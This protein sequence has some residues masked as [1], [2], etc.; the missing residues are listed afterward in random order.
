MRKY[1][2]FMLVFSLA[3]SSGLFIL[4]E[5]TE[6]A[7]SAWQSIPG[8]SGCKVRVWTDYTA[9]TASADTNDYCGR[10]E[11]KEM[12]ARQYGSYTFYSKQ[13][14]NGYFSSRTP[15]K[16]FN[17]DMFSLKINTTMSDVRVMALVWKDGKAGSSTLV[18]SLP[19]TLYK[20]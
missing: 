3:I 16:V 8:I 2:K 11:Y 6:A 14:Y 5:K 4:N 20:R 18:Q 7:T 12:E 1:L 10:L 15:T 17:L 19:L 9:Y 13:N